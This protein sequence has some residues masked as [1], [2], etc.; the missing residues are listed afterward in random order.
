M[1]AD[2]AQGQDGWSAQTDAANSRRR[3]VL[4][5]LVAPVRSPAAEMSDFRRIGKRVRFANERLDRAA[6]FQKAPPDRKRRQHVGNEA[7]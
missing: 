7:S 6:A 5:V 1:G 3:S 2:Q 4:A